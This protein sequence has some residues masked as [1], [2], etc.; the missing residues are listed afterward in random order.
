VLFGVSERNSDGNYSLT[1]QDIDTGKY[2]DSGDDNVRALTQEHVN[3]LIEHIKRRPDH[4]LW[5][6][7]RFKHVVR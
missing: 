1:F 7:R 2:A 3:L 5:F 6:H 4:W